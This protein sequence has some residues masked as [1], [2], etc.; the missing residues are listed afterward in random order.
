MKER[1]FPHYD[2]NLQYLAMRKIECDC[3]SDLLYV[4]SP[5]NTCLHDGFVQ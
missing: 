1:G 5:A 2:N 4:R 3:A